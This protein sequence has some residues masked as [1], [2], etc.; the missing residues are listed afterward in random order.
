MTITSRAA[1]RRLLAEET[2]RLQKAIQSQEELTRPGAQQVGDDADHASRDVDKSKNKT[3]VAHLK[4]LLAQVE[5][6]RERLAAGTYGICMDC[7]RPIPPERLEV[8][9][10]ATLC[11]ACQSRREKTRPGGSGPRPMLIQE[12]A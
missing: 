5:S 6:A 3:V 7:G 1:L 8:L 4:Q 2:D 10:Y 12:E 9:P 11:V